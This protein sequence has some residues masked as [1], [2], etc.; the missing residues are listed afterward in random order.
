MKF[1]YLF[2]FAYTTAF[3][4]YAQEQSGKI[5]GKIIDNNGA[6]AG[7]SVMLKN[8][9]SG[10]LTQADGSFSMKAPVGKQSLLIQ[11]IGYHAFEK[12]IEVKNNETLSLG[13]IT[14]S[15]KSNDLQDVVITGQFGLQSVRNSVYQVRTIT[16]EQIRL[17]GATN[18]QSVLNTELGMRFS[19]D[20]TL[21]TTD[22]QLMGMS[23]QNVKVLLDGVPLVDR[24]ST[25]ES[26]GQIDINIIDR[27]EIVEGPMSVTYGSDALAGVINIITKKGEEGANWTLTGRVQEETAGDEYEP[28]NGKGTHNE[29]LGLAW[30]KK[31][32][33]VSGNFTRNFFGGWQGLSTG[34][35]KEWMPKEQY[36][37]TAGISYRNQKFNGWYRFNGTNETL[38]SLGNTY[39]NTQTNNLSATDQYYITNRWFHQL[40]GEYQFNAKNSLTA[41]ASYT[42]Y[43]R[44]T[45]TT[46]ID[47]VRDRRTLSL[48]QG[49]QDKA[50][51]QTT[52]VRLTGQHKFSSQVS[53][54]HGLEANINSSSGA[55]IEGTPSISEFAYFASSELKIGS[56]INIRPGLRFIKNSVYDAP[57]VIP[58]INTKFTLAKGVDLRV[59]YAR[60]FRSP[61]LRELY[62]TF[63]DSNHAIRGNTN[64]KA[65][66][67]NSFNAFLSYQVFEKPKLRLNSTLGGFYNVFEN[68]IS[69]GV[70]PNDTRVSTYLNVDLYKTTGLTWNNTLYLEN[71]QLTL[72]YS[73]IGRFNR[74]STS[75]SLPEFVWSSEINSNI[76]YTFSKIAASISLFYKFT[77]K[78]PSYQ[79][80]STEAGIQTRLAE[81]SSFHTSD[82]TFNKVFYKNFSLL[83]GVKNLFDVTR[84]NNSA[85]DTGGAH[86]AGG[87][88]VPMSYGRSYFLGLSAQISKH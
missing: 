57:P 14:L 86:S 87:G 49:S 37:T 62:F 30:Q 58:S 70:D 72:G 64:L 31:G 10:Q 61:A 88:A 41:A 43:S 17:R 68:L 60:G 1:L 39:I 13:T 18:I 8:T 40:Q 26:I 65:E 54:Q 55:R 23:G 47:L 73:H 75:E 71:L 85:V 22:V 53:L 29:F 77:G 12:E 79:A 35:A 20:L 59:A 32:L 5:E 48:T 82:L 6:I 27:I 25:R 50:I 78:Q 69:I 67:S 63:F 9:R 2:L 84:I 21:G 51:F 11:F 28:F 80:V 7:A 42:D 38:K 19:N 16:N 15:E 45:Q 4:T 36:L 3:T 74:F 46:D 44:K 56:N 33:Q 66:Y 76:R 83:A 81:T 34:R 24:G 52:F